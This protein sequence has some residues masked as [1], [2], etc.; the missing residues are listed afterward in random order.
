MA[1]HS[2][3]QRAD[4][5]MA[6]RA[7]LSELE[8]AGVATLD[9][10]MAAQIRAHHDA[11][12]TRLAAETE[13]DLSRG[14][15]RLSAGMR[16]ASIL[17][18]AA[19]SAA[20]GF[21]VAATWNDIGRPA[22]LALVTIPPILLTI[23]TAVA[24]RREKSGYVASIVATVATIA[25]G[26][27]LA[28]LGVL[29]DLPD[30]RNLL[31][32]VGS[33]A[34]ILA[35]GYGLVLPLLGGIVGIGGWLWSLAAIPQG[36]WWD[37][38]YGDFE[39]LALL[40]LGAMFLPRLLRRG[41]PSFTTTWRA[42]GAAAVM[43]AL[44]A[45]GETHSASLFDGMNKALL[46]GSYQLLGGAS[47][48]VMIWQGLARDRSELVRMGTIGMGMLLFLRSVDWFWDL[49][50]KWLFFLLVGALAFGTLL[51]LRRLR[52]AERRLS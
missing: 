35:Y 4:R 15:A 38:A 29:Y 37:G 20:W 14:E 8:A 24:A 47:F 18:A 33:F 36:L 26:V 42:C 31:L 34:M 9:P 27:N 50:P 1:T 6:F 22:R 16:A 21:F 17:G 52:L 46:E 19:L 40:G 39:P 49:M 41:P 2:A 7:E 43:V 3:Q 23:G 28:A 10:M 11:V 45:L 32:A 30:S 25:F 51:L 44:L 5:I 13:V 48:A 12:L